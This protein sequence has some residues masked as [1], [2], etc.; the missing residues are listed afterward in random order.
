MS[1]GPHK[2]LP[3]RRPWKRVCE[4]AD[5]A[6]HALEE[7]IERIPAALS[8]DARGELSDGFLSR[9]RRALALDPAQPRLFDDVRQALAAVRTR[10]RSTMEADLADA[11][12]DAIRDGFS[13]LGALR[14]GIATALHERGQA[15]IRAVEEHYLMESPQSRAAHVR[16]RLQAALAAAAG[17]V[18]SL[19]DGLVDGA[20]SL[21]VAPAAD[22]SGLDEGPKL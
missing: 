16:S 18:A 11:V 21:A 9:M 15:A 6:A 2:S 5:N 22:R 3:M 4:I 12:I 1:D 8:A 13:G 10:A 20:V 17:G 19:A 7:V 14:R